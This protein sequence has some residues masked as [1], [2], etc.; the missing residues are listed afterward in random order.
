MNSGKFC[1]LT[2][3]T[4]RCTSCNKLFAVTYAQLHFSRED[5]CLFSPCCFGVATLHAITV[6]TA[7]AKR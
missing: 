1:R 7:R 2:T 6:K 3:L 5:G 4:A